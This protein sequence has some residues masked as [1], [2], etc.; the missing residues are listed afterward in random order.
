M[1]Q[2]NPDVV[3]VSGARGSCPTTTYKVCATYL[4]GY[5]ATSV[6]IVAGGDAAAKARKTA[7]ALIK[8]CKGIFQK[9]GIII[10]LYKLSTN[11]NLNPV[12]LTLFRSS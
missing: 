7:N 8:R 4:A 1:D 6:S 5:K 2:T 12:F 3:R 10:Y 11:K 9:L